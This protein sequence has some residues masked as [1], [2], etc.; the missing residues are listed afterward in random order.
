MLRVVSR[1]NAQAAGAAAIPACWVE[2]TTFHRLLMAIALSLHC[3]M[4]LRR[5]NIL[6]RQDFS[7][8]EQTTNTVLGP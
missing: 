3:L 1:K 4:K 5:L 6:G 7:L 2:R 8:K